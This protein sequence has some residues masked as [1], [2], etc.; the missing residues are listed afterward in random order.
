MSRQADPAYGV[1]LS[2]EC[3][4]VDAAV[5]EIVDLLEFLMEH[6][7]SPKSTPEH[8]EKID[9]FCDG[10]PAKVFPSSSDEQQR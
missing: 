4:N 1:E 7:E 10:H 9:S 3:L 2:D 6:E 8:I 5:R